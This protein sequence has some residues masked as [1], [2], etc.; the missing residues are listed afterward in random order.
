MAT[1]YLDKDGLLYFLQ[2]IRPNATPL[3]DG[4]ASVGTAKKFANQDHVHPHDST[5]VDK[6]SGKGL[7]TN[8][9][10]TAEK[11]K[12]AGIAAGAEVNVQSNWSQTDSTADDYIK[13][14]P[15]I[16]AAVPKTTTTPKMDGTAAIGSE[17]KYAAGD[18]VHPTDTSRAPNNHASTATTYGSGTSSNYGHVKLSDATDGTAA[19]ASGG[20]AAT[21]KAVSDALTAAKAYADNLDTGVSDVQYNG[22]SVLSGSVANIPIIARYGTCSDSA[23]S[24]AKSVTCTGFELRTGAM[25][26]VLF[27]NGCNII[28]T[29]NVN[30]TGAKNV[31]FRGNTAGGQASVIT[32]PLEISNSVGIFLYDGTYYTLVSVTYS[33]VA[34]GRDG[35]MTSDDKSKLDGI[36][37]GAQVNPT[38]TAFN[39][40]PASDEA[41]T[42]G[43]SVTVSQIHQSASGQVSGTNRTIRI[44]NQLAS[45]A[46]NGLM[47]SADKDKL[48]GISG[49]VLDL[50]AGTN[51]TL[52]PNT[53][54]GTLTI[55]ASVPSSGTSTELSNGTVTN[56]RVWTP[57]ILHDYISN[58]IE[59]AVTGAAAFQGT[60][61]T[62]FAPTTYKAGYYWV[63]GTAGTYV[64]Q[65]CEAGDMIFAI[66][67][68]TSYSASNFDVVQTNLDITSITNSEID[69]IVA[70]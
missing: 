39:G 31:R 45:S 44:P 34:T 48:D 51:I 3:E 1:S 43:S 33:T 30:S 5:K 57:K 27:A 61:P 65:T 42:F 38:Y 52:T 56:T 2:Q 55:A 28:K 70:S 66:A 59:T 49:V 32:K 67:D 22:T 68:G 25:V 6:V 9:Y 50:A 11:N 29:L 21:P 13:N 7:S 15:T 64:G 62:T 23:N 54:S 53:T 24:T 14:K 18:H 10:T 69:T 60:A 8:D 36:E 41:P 16:P 19:A 4:T 40:F 58:A 12:L 35:L 26:A 20:T 37:S 63:V 46:G 17:T 47:S